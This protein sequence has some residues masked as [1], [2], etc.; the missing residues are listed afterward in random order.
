LTVGSSVI[1]V[2]TYVASNGSNTAVPA[3]IVVSGAGNGSD[4]ATLYD[5]FGTNAFVIGGSS[6]QLTTPQS[7]TTVNSFAKVTAVRQN[8]STDTKQQTSAIDFSFST[9]G[10]W[11]AG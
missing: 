2:N 10:N 4:I 6:A 11:T 7:T 9:V 5:A 8:G 3:Q 1:T